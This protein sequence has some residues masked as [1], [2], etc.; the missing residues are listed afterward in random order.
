MT[1]EFEKVCKRQNKKEKQGN[2]LEQ[3]IKDLVKFRRFFG[4]GKNSQAYREVTNT[5]DY[6][7]FE[8][9]LLEG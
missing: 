1:T 7:R 3:L 8:L 5:I 9:K 6:V 4:A 2:E